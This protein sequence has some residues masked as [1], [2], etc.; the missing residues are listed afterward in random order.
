MQRTP[1]VRGDLHWDDVRLFLAL[2]RARTVGSAA[3]ELGVDSST[4]SRR[5]AAL[6]EALGATLFDRG[7]D[8]IT[9]TEAAEDLMP[10]AEEIEGVMTRFANAAEGLEREPAG[11]VRITC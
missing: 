3:A 10:I 2:C 6:E 1:M 9:A 7:R 11:L 5:L 8:G 4:V